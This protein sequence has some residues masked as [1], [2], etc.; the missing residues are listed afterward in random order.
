M[1][2]PRL[3][4]LGWSLL[5]LHSACSPEPDPP[6]TERVFTAL[7]PSALEDGVDLRYAVV[8]NLGRDAALRVTSDGE[9]V[10]GGG[11]FEVEFVAPD[12]STWDA[13]LLSH[14]LVFSDLTWLN[15]QQPRVLLYRDG[16]RNRRLDFDEVT[17]DAGP[18]G[19]SL[20]A[21]DHFIEGSAAFIPH[22]AQRAVAQL[23]WKV[24]FIRH[25]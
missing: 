7:F 16:D 8:W 19:D 17:S 22:V 6:T 18:N 20:L 12:E 13:L 25:D 24:K 4:A 11:D 15:V 1:S 9:L 10:A 23:R 21:I 14:R 2:R 3:R 5:A